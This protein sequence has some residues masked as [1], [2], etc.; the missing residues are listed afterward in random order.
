MQFNSA[1]ES[2]TQKK[3]TLRS[4]C[5]TGLGDPFSPCTRRLLQHQPA[6]PS[7]KLPQP[8]FSKMKADVL[9]API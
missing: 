6:L 3:I 7:F 1:E 4:P 9:F 5:S 8:S 2:T